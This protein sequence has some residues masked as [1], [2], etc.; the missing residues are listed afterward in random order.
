MPRVRRS[1]LVAL[2]APLADVESALAVLPDG[3]TATA[4]DSKETVQVEL[5]AINDTFV[6]Y[7][8]W[9]YAP[10]IRAT[11]RRRLRFGVGVIHAH[12]AGDPLPTEPKPPPLMPRV[13]YSTE[14]ITVLATCACA[15][16]LVTLGGSLYGQNGDAIA[17]TFDISNSQLGLGLA[18]TRLGVMV[19]LVAAASAD[20]LGRRRLILLC[21]GVVAVANAFAAVAPSYQFFV[22]TQVLA[23]ACTTATLVVAGIAVVEEAP[24][25][26]RAQS[27]SLLAL[28]GGAGFAI[29][30]VLLPLADLGRNG[31]RLAFLCSAATV[32]LLPSLARNL[33][34]TTRFEALERRH[35]RTGRFAELFDARYRSRFLLLALVAFLTSVFSAPSAQLTN[36]FLID[37]HGFSNTTIAIFRT[38]T[39]G[40][41]GLVGIVLAGYLA[42]QRGRRPVLAIALALSTLF[43]IVVYLAGG[44]IIWVASTFA[45]I[46]AASAGIALGTLDGELFPTEVRGTSNGVLL[47]AGVAGAITGLL[48]AS[49]L[50]DNLGG[51][52]PAIALCGIGPIIAAVAVVPWLPETRDRTLDNVSPSEV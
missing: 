18:V 41:P 10:I 25:R 6:P 24:E 22:A 27:V 51:L 46:T 49:N 12:L 52:G 42:E 47:L 1:L 8:H 11:L 39:N 50:D 9:F 28:G 31:W 34:E 16:A 37:E 7:F 23:R 45:I 13:P 14:Q 19:A 43:E 26:A 3:V 36:R 2:D 38:V 15:A 21:F 48:V 17:K 32:V 44:P 35:A 33:K 20:R 30:V 29:S 4:R 5:T 40:L